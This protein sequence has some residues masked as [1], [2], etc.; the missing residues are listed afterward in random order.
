MSDNCDISKF[1]EFVENFLHNLGLASLYL[2]EHSVG[3]DVALHYTLR[4]PYTIK[5]LV[6][7][8][9]MCLG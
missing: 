5:R 4:L 6:L 2:I 9:S 3:G 7:V 1:V 8:S